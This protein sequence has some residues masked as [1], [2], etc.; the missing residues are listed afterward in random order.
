MTEV[1]DVIRY[2]YFLICAILERCKKWKKRLEDMPIQVSRYKNMSA[3]EKKLLKQVVQASQDYGL[4]QQNDHIMVCM[5][6]GKDSYAMLHLLMIIQK[7]APFDFSLTAVNLD[8]GHPGFPG[9]RLESY[10]QQRMSAH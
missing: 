5:S 2:R 6:G 8:Q 10:F 1:G 7:K 3:V 4:I 9:E